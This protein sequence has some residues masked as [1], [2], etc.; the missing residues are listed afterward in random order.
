MQSKRTYLKDIF[1]VDKKEVICPQEVVQSVGTIFN[2][3]EVT[4]FNS[5]STLLCGHVT[6]KKNKKKNKKR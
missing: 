6:K 5:S 3:S 1:Y 2:E 4:S